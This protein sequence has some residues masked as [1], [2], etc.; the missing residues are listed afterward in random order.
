MGASQQHC[1]P[2][3]AQVHLAVGGVGGVVCSG[4][5]GGGPFRVGVGDGTDGVSVIY[6]FH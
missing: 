3:H 1:F 2:R 4:C 5:A 6:A